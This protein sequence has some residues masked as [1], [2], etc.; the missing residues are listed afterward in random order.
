M[1]GAG[2]LLIVGAAVLVAWGMV[3]LTDTGP[4]RRRLVRGAT[5]PPSEVQPSVSGN[6]RR[7]LLWWAVP[8]AFVVNLPFS[9]AAGFSMCG[10]SG[11]SGG[12]FG[13]SE[14]GRGS[15]IPLLAIGGVVLALPFVLI[16]WHPRRWVRLAFGLGI[17]VTWTVL[18]A[19]WMYSWV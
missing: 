14:I 2:L 3:R 19:L 10:I 4:A 1:I 15:V 8:L 12:G 17:A 16:R 5:Q 9:W 13:V 7:S 18:N 6:T 11:C